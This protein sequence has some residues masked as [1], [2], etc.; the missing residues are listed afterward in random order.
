MLRCA[1][2]ALLL[3][4]AGCGGVKSDDVRDPVAQNVAEAAAN[5]APAAQAAAMDC[6]N[7]PDFVPIYTGGEVTTC[8]SGPDGTR[9]GHVSG[10]IV[11]LT[12][13][14]PGRVLA[15]SRERA[16]AAGLGQRLSTPASYSAG[17]EGERSVTIRVEPYRDRTRVTVAW[18]GG[19]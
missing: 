16:N 4:L 2:P 6:G 7:R 13:A 10:N 12:D 5:G 9:R 14:D 3:L 8:V 15:W 18:G 11:Y 17:E 19:S 1:I